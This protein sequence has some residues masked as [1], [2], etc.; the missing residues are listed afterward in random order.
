MPEL[1][2]VET[3][4][5]GAVHSLIGQKIVLVSILLH[6]SFIGDPRAVEGCVITNVGRRGKLLILHTSGVNSILI[7]LKMTGQLISVRKGQ[8]TKLPDKSTKVIFAFESEDKLFF[9]DY[10]TFGYVQVFES[11]NLSEHPFLKKVG[12]EPLDSS[13]TFEFFEKLVLRFNKMNVKSFLLDQ[14]K[15]AGLG[16][17]Y[18]DEALFYAH[19]LPMRQI[20]SL[21]TIELKDLY[22]NIK[23]VLNKGVNLGGSSKTSYVNLHG[24]KGRFLSQAAVYGRGGMSCI[25]CGQPIQKSKCAGRGTHYCVHCQK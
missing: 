14:T 13:F 7:H 17:I 1:P 2:E 8:M 18:T 24:E 6:K 21:D 5:R 19:I 4:R 22:L 25:V 9:N 3:I 15:I 10:R 12:I 23:E 20:G 11:A 16:N